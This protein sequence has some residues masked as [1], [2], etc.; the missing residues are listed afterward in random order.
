MWTP[1]VA[2]Q[3]LRER[4]SRALGQQAAAPAASTHVRKV[5]P[6]QPATAQPLPQ[7]PFAPIQP[8]MVPRPAAPTPTPTP[9]ASA[10]AHP[11][12]YQPVCTLHY[13]KIMLFVVWCGSAR[14]LCLLSFHQDSYRFILRGLWDFGTDLV[15]SDLLLSCSHF[16]GWISITSQGLNHT[17]NPKCILEAA[18]LLTFIHTLYFVTCHV[19]VI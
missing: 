10:P 16:I 11:Q 15:K 6:Q 7:H 1:Q 17:R 14:N 19:S 4:L 8:T 2:I 13:S 12:Y 5:H 18:K 9:A 3:Q